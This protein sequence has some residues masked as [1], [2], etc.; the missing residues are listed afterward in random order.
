MKVAFPLRNKTELAIDFIR[1]QAIGIYDELSEK[2]EYI[3]IQ[4]KSSISTMQFLENFRTQGVDCV[5]SPDFSCQ[6]LRSFRAS[7]IKTYKASDEAIEVN[8]KRLFS[9]AL[10]L[11]N[12]FDR[13]HVDECSS[14]CNGCGKDQSYIYVRQNS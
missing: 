5:I 10:S 12:R 4:D 7:N 11:F 14:D 9:K 1:C 6:E 2:V 13:Y 3:T 8:I